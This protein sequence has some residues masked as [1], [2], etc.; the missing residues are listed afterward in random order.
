MNRVYGV[1]AGID[2]H[3]RMLAV[4]VAVLGEQKIEYQQRKFGTSYGALEELTKW[5][6]E[7]R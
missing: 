1:V 5:L 4:V 6:G 3:K 7:H 2:A